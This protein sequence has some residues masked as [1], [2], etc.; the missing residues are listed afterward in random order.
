MRQQ[1]SDEELPQSFHWSI[2][3]SRS[4]SANRCNRKFR[5]NARA[6]NEAPPFGRGR[7]VHRDTWVRVSAP[8]QGGEFVQRTRGN[9]LAVDSQIRMRLRFARW[10]VWPEGV[11]HHV[12]RNAEGCLARKRR[13][14]LHPLAKLWSVD[15]SP[16]FHEY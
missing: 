8:D 3:R 15:G 1:R 10:V 5:T 12:S 6:W 9:L 13:P 11:V 16:P 4:I 7:R 2:R 14:L